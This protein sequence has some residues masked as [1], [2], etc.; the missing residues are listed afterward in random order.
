MCSMLLSLRL[1]SCR[2]PTNRW[3]SSGEWA[4]LAAGIPDCS[5]V[6]QQ[7][8]PA[9][10][11]FSSRAAS[12]AASACASVGL[13]RCW[14]LPGLPLLQPATALNCNPLLLPPCRFPSLPAPCPAV[15]RGGA[16][17]RH[18]PYPTPPLLPTWASASPWED[19]P[20]FCP[21]RPTGRRCAGPAMSPSHGAR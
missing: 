21:P 17:W 9:A 1:P 12:A 5:R 14:C 7:G 18:M 3:L 4:E 20:G 10:Q 15:T 6:R 8:W 2:A 11:E 19:S 16:A 13:P